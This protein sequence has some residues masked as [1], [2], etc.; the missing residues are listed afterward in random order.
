MTN[1]SAIFM[2]NPSYMGVCGGV[3]NKAC[4]QKAIKQGKF[5]TQISYYNIILQ[6]VLVMVPSFTS[7]PNYSSR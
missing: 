6:I 4:K 1:S 2:K 5:L 7:F 3:L